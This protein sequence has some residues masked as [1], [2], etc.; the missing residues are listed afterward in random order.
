MET[1]LKMREE[2]LK[3]DAAPRLRDTSGT[4]QGKQSF[5]FAPALTQLITILVIMG[6]MILLYYYFLK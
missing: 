1:E 4:F 5:R 3:R 6:G 2:E